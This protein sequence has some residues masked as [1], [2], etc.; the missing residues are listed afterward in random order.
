MANDLVLDEDM[1]VLD[2]KQWPIYLNDKKKFS[3][4]YFQRN[5]TTNKLNMFCLFLN[6]AHL[7][8]HNMRTSRW[9]TGLLCL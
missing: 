3:I 8:K 4:M 6:S 2:G 5:M 1:L 7:Y 9:S